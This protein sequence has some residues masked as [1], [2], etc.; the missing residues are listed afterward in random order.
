M[1]LIDLECAPVVL[2]VVSAF[3]T[4]FYR[5]VYTLAGLCMCAHESSQDRVAHRGVRDEIGDQEGCIR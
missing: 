1:T 3:N 4:I 5:I 2:N